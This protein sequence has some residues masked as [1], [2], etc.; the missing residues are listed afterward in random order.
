[1]RTTPVA[2]RCGCGA[3]D[4]HTHIVPAEFPPYAG[5]RSGVRWPAM[6]PAQPC[7]RH[8]MFGGELFRTVSHQSWDPVVR[9]ADAERMR[10]AHQVLSP[11][12]ELL[13]Y[14]L[15]GED[16]V[17][18]GRY[19]NEQVAAMVA[20]APARFTG[21][22]TVPLQDVEL[23]IREL[24]RA[25]HETGLAGVEIGSNV[26]GVPIGD[27]R[28][29]PFFEAAQE[30]GAAVFVHA[31]RPTGMDRLVGPPVLEHALAY[32]TEV[33]LAAASMITGGTLHRC[34]RLRI[35]FSHG[36][37]TLGQMLPRLQHAWDIFPALQAQVATAPTELARRAYVDDLVY[38]DHAIR[39]LLTVFGPRQVLLGSD[40]PFAIMDPDPVG[41]L[42]AMALDAALLQDL[43]HGN[44][45]R[46]LDGPSPS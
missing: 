30:W 37:G 7:H 31:L 27:P 5:T 25:L 26:N 18:L 36:A 34:P 45:V 33:G 43:T 38:G 24:D 14:W 1:M 42:D 35:A 28:F 10:L 41:R 9:E 11:M 20:Q 8:V 21:L 22:G 44:A 29:L 46:W 3:I 23:A 17:S 15:E 40:Y 13:A 16:A 39:H 6:A 4:V 2:S 19:L 12:P 32:P